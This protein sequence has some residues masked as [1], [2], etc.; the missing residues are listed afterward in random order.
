VRTAVNM[1]GL[2][3]V[4]SWA[5]VLRHGPGDRRVDVL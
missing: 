3:Y 2:Q 1:H 5:L 4:M